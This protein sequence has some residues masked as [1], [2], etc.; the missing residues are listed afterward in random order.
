VESVKIKRRPS[1]ADRVRAQSAEAL[2]T[3][4]SLARART[5]TP[6]FGK[7]AEFG[8]WQRARQIGE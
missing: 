2:E 3:S 7:G 5:L 1:A 6:L 4:V 8:R